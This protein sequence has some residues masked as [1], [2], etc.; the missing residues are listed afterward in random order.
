VSLMSINVWRLAGDTLHI[1]CN[2]LYCNHQ[3]HRDVLITL[4][5]KVSSKVFC[6]WSDRLIETT[7]SDSAHCP[8]SISDRWT[9]TMV[10]NSFQITGIYNVVAMSRSKRIILIP[11]CHNHVMSPLHK[12]GFVILHWQT[13]DPAWPQTKH[14]ERANCL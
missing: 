6:Q 12:D 4:H 8:R 10:R 3:V 2:F 9:G 11:V 13:S 5:V 14:C 1:T 7:L